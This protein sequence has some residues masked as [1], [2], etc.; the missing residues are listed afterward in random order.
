MII[1][2]ANWY[3]FA[4]ENAAMYF[5]AYWD[6]VTERHKVCFRVKVGGNVHK[7]H[8]P[9]N[10]F[11]LKYQDKINVKNKTKPTTNVIYGFL[12]YIEASKIFSE[13]YKRSIH[14]IRLC[15]VL[16]VELRMLACY[17]NFAWICFNTVFGYVRWISVIMSAIWITYLVVHTYW[18]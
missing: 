3:I 1:F 4:N 9:F 15:I 2:T 12:N 7:M 17:S 5:S 13:F 8:N 10:H 18:A 16:P 11:G 14:I 6:W